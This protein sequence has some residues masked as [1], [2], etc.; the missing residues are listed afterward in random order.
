MERFPSEFRDLLS[1]DARRLFESACS[2]QFDIRRQKLSWFPLVLDRQVAE[3][4]IRL[5]E[6]ALER[7]LRPIR[8]A[9]PKAAITSMKRAYSEKLPKTLSNHSVLLNGAGGKAV[10]SARQIGLLEMMNS[11][12]LRNLAEWLTG[13]ELMPDPSCQ[14]ICYREGDYVGPHND[15]HPDVAE[16]RKGFVDV[17]LTLSTPGVSHQWLV[18]EDRG[19]LRNVHQVGVQSGLSVSFLPFWHFTTPLVVH[20]DS[21]LTARRWLVLVSYATRSGRRLR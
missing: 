20:P 1:Q 10:A 16:L 4:S 3:G 15:H 2:N 19:W 9:I 17:Q 5:L 11:A 14:V 13:F 8:S 6:S 18:F 12:T 7:H 21:S